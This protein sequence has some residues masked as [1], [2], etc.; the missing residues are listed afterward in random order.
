MGVTAMWLNCMFNRIIHGM[1]QIP[2][3]PLTHFTLVS[4]FSHTHIICRGTKQSIHTRT[5][6]LFVALKHDCLCSPRFVRW[7]QWEI[8]DYQTNNDKYY[9]GLN[10]HTTKLNH[11]QML[12]VHTAVSILCEILSG[13]WNNES[14]VHFFFLC[15][16]NNKMDQSVFPCSCLVETPASQRKLM[17][18]DLWI[19]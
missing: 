5:S 4:W 15:A 13:L 3:R 19:M 18:I 11:W 9:V 10:A 14:I 17:C 12:E 2:E 7:N 8:L 1:L 16:S 6:C